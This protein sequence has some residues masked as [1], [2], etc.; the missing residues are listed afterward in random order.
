MVAARIYF[1]RKLFSLWQ[2]RKRSQAP[3]E[4]SGVDGPTPGVCKAHTMANS[5]VPHSIP[6]LA[7]I[8]RSDVRFI[9]VASQEW[10]W[11]SQQ[12]SPHLH[13]CRQTNK[14]Q[15]RKQ[16]PFLTESGKHVTSQERKEAQHHWWRRQGPF[17]MARGWQWR[18][19]QR[20]CE[21]ILVNRHQKSIHFIDHTLQH[22]VHHHRQDGSSRRI[23]KGLV[24]SKLDS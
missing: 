8:F 14:G 23:R 6:K 17:G 15:R 3:L 1:I 24:Q 13:F 10:K 9:V 22:W 11:S 5:G 4:N 12:K 18:W 21:C 19:L 7:H 2:D 16:R 20:N